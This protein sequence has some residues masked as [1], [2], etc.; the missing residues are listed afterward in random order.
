M[1]PIVDGNKRFEQLDEDKKDDTTQ[2]R[3]VKTHTD[4]HNTSSN[5]KL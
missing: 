5:S 1:F 2:D 3:T 4:T